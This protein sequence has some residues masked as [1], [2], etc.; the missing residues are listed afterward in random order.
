MSAQLALNKTKSPCHDSC[1]LPT[2]L[3]CVH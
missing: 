2:Y 1:A 3:P